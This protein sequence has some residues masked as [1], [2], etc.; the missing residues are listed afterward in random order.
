MPDREVRL[1]NLTR[2]EF[3][4]ARK[5]GHFKLAIIPTGSVEQHLEHL[6]M[7]QDISS[8]T[9]VAEQVANTLYP[10]VIVTVPM[11]I[12]ISEHHM[13][14]PGT[15]TANPGGWLTVLFDTVES[16]VRHGIKNVLI[17]NGHGG[18][19]K[20]IEGS[21]RHWQLYFLSMYG[22]L[23]STTSSISRNT[24]MEYKAK[25][26]ENGEPE[27]NL[28]FCSYWD[29]IP[30]KFA[31]K[32]LDTGDSPGHATEFE[33]S[34]AMYAFP[35]NV[36]PLTIPRN[37]DTTPSLATAQKGKLLMGKAIEGVSEIVGKML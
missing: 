37:K 32:V 24:R 36:R 4:D 15:L 6:T 28:N 21:L 29:V 11:A 34:I 7:S 3:R 27:V 12:G 13:G 23:S 31:N 14:F 18:N 26:L 10:K 16:L 22:A 25:L 8:S 30:Q 17:L 5:E 33:T 1:E 20:P 19:V 9:Y 35:E 2:L